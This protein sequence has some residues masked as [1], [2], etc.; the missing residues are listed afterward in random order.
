MRLKLV[1]WY[2]DFAIYVL[3]HGAHTIFCIGMRVV[4]SRSSKMIK[5]F[6]Y[7]WYAESCQQTDNSV[8]IVLD[9]L[10]FY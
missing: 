6:Q 1:L 9:S 8:Y 2:Y 7:L 4:C 10:H 3:D 5:S